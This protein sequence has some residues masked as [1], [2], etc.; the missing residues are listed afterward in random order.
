M[1]YLQR[2][3][4]GSVLLAVA[5][6]AA[7]AAPESAITKKYTIDMGTQSG[8][9]VLYLMLDADVTS[10]TN[11]RQD[12]RSEAS[13]KVAAALT[14]TA[15]TP[16][17]VVGGMS[18]FAQDFIEGSVAGGKL[19]SGTGGAKTVGNITIPLLVEESTTYAMEWRDE[20]DRSF[21]WL[22]ETGSYYGSSMEL[23]FGGGCEGI[24]V[25]YASK[26][27]REGLLGAAYYCGTDNRPGE[28]N[29]TR[30]SVFGPKGCRSKTVTLHY[31]SSEI[32]ER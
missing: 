28:S 9:N 1:I 13:T 12:A 22:P 24:I 21:V 7:C 19:T 18:G 8:S 10:R 14:P 2:G 32:T 27:T 26:N 25:P 29:G 6:L 23:E 17:S 4:I 5:L 16:A 20:H 30:A 11:L 3:F 31:L 15:L